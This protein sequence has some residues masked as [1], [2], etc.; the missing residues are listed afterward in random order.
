MAETK[1]DVIVV[2]SGASGG[3]AAKVLSESGLHVAVIDCG[4]PQK[5]SNFNEHEPVFNLKYRNMRV[6]EAVS[7]I[8][9][10]T[11][12]IQGQCYACTEYNY[13]WFA[14]DHEEP[15]TTAP[16]MDYNYFGRIR[17][18]GGRTNVWG[19]QSYRLSDLNFKSAS[20]DG[21]GEN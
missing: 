16:S 6:R 3:W 11:R 17:M 21:F 5:D 4:R 7:P 10:K 8:I 13:K 19:R 14:N 9:S 20:Y 2:G 1:Y 18:V 12:P 15:Y